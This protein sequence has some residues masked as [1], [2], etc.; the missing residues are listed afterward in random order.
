M[1]PQ[2]FY[3]ALINGQKLLAENHQEVNRIN[4]FPVADND[5]G[6][7]LLNSIEN[8]YINIDG[9][10]SI[11]KQ[12]ECFT[13]YLFSK[14]SGNSGFILS[15]LLSELSQLIVEIEDIYPQSFANKLLQ[16]SNKAK[17]K[18]DSYVEGTMLS[19]AEELAQSILSAELPHWSKEHFSVIQKAQSISLANTAKHNIHLKKRGVVDSGAM[20]LHYWLEGFFA[21]L[22]QVHAEFELSQPTA[23]NLINHD[24]CHPI[25]FDEAPTLRYCVQATI[26]I[27]KENEHKLR[28]DLSQSG[29]CTLCINRNNRVRFHIHTNQPQILFA[30]IMQYAEVDEI[31]VEDMLMQY[32]ASQSDADIAIV[33]DSTANIPKEILEQHAVYVIPISIIQGNQKMLDGLTISQS[34]LA[35]QIA[36]NSAYPKTSL[37]APGLI[38]RTLQ[39]LS[40]THKHVIAIT[41]SAQMSGTYQ[42]FSQVAAEFD[43]VSVIDSKRNSAAHGLVVRSIVKLASQGASVQ[44]ILERAES[45]IKQKQIYVL[46]D[47]LDAMAKG[48]RVTQKKARVA[49]FL[50][51]KPLVSVDSLG[52][53]IV[54]KKSFSKASQVNK[55]I[56]V[57]KKKHREQPIKRFSILHVQNQKEATD[58]E[59]KVIS[60]LPAESLGVQEASAVIS[61]HAGSG[62]LAIAIDQE[63]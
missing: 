41:I 8:I 50:N 49:N 24:D 40:N 37:P 43:N 5:T 18:V 63:H 15:I 23:N 38:K 1:T 12:F 36:L 6:T 26:L 33:T 46:V 42:A 51:L 30:S 57:L 25:I 10:Q 47:N 29:D 28:Q 20:G 19:Y 62:A 3:N 55:L 16:A 54:I 56:K 31:K 4:I 48:G 32:T 34:M 11:P 35:K 7:N 13:E 22:C 21:G 9:T 2:L 39:H 17:Q 14:A 53:G 44:Q 60:I 45:I 27:D 59:Q 61:L 52:K 58:L